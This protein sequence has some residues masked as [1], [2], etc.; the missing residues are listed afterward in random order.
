MRK[1]AWQ[2]QKT[3]TVRLIKEEDN[4]IATSFRSTIM[5]VFAIGVHLLC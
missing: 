3:Q 5:E 1:S 4:F 2:P